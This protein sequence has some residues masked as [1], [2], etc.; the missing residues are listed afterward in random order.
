[1]V[2]G[3]CLCGAVRYEISGRISP[4]A[5]CHC[6]KCRRATGTAFH[7]GALCRQ[8]K[9]RWLQ[10]EEAIRQYSTTSGYTT[11]FCGVCGSPVPGP[12]RTGEY[13]VLPSGALDGD[14]GI[15][16]VHHMF[17]ASRA[18]WFEI[19]DGLPQFE[20]RPPEEV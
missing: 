13:M 3:G 19:T 17:V 6:S 12:D 11:R 16:P 20:G 5:L 18:A 1:M 10:G 14:P 9:F 4:I 2:A 8:R 7:A 15:K